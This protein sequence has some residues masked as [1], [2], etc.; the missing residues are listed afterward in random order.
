MAERAGGVLLHPTSLPGPHGIGDLGPEATRWLD[1]LQAA[2]CRLW[3]VLPLGPTGFADSPYQSFSSFAG[4]PLLIS[5]D[6]LVEDGLLAAADVEQAPIF[7]SDQIDFGAVIEYKGRLLS[8]AAARFVEKASPSL[9]AEQEAFARANAAWLDDFALFMALKEAH[10]GGAWTEWPAELVR[11]D[12]ESLRRA[13]AGLHEAVDRHRLMQYLF[14]RQWQELHEA[15]RQA[16]VTLIGDVPIFVAHDSAD[17]WAHPDLFYLDESGQPSVVA[18]VP[19]DY[20]S[21]TGQKWGNPLYRWDVLRADGY[22]WWLARLQSVL[23]MVDIVRLDHFRGFEA[24][25]E[26]PIS[27]PTAETGRWVPGPGADLL[28]SLQRGLGSLPIIAEDL[29]VITPEVVA[30]RDGFDLPGMKV[31]QFA[32]DGDPDHEFLPHN[33][34]RRC[35][36]Y[37]GTHDNDTAVGWYQSAPEDSRDFCRRYL[38]RDGRDVAWDLVRAAWGS[39]ADSAIAPLQDFLGLG[40]E[41]RMNFP[42]RAEGNWRWRFTRGQLSDELAARLKEFN[43]VYGRAARP[44]E[45]SLVAAG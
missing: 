13:R 41:A 30:L 10:G 33:H 38:G 17:V 31:L 8:T 44:T 3:Q 27:A 19:P 14:H 18:G 7:P 20:F 22:A 4:N 15:A 39:V 11:R 23:G 1:W 34:V 45:P 37:T 29:G 36:V 28:D 24:Y 25:W 40:P 21:P 5:P 42:S 26:I 35:V 16:G 2:G 32:F 12:E 43:L 9:R 6:R